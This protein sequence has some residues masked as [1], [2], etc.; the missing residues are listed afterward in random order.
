MLVFIEVTLLWL[1]PRTLRVD[2]VENWNSLLLSVSFADWLLLVDE[3]FYH[4]AG[5]VRGVECVFQ[6]LDQCLII[7]DGTLLIATSGLVCQEEHVTRVRNI[8]FTM[9]FLLV[10]TGLGLS[11]PFG[12]ALDVY[13]FDFLSSFEQVLKRVWQPIAFVLGVAKAEYSLKHSLIV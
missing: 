11:F 13:G 4:E 1:F 8:A 2:R 7:R 3:E 5:L 12:L 9:I 10:I 6:G